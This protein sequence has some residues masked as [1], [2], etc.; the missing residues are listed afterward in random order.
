[1]SSPAFKRASICDLVSATDFRRSLAFLKENPGLIPPR[2]R[3]TYGDAL[4]EAGFTD[5]EY[6][7]VVLVLASWQHA[8]F[9][10]TY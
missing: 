4:K 10:R 2:I 3:E 1:M 8:F 7:A 9:E 5:S 6:N